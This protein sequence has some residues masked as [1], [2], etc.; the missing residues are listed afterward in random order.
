MA[1]KALPL[2]HSTTH[3]PAGSPGSSAKTHRKLAS[4]SPPN[5]FEIVGLP[6]KRKSWQTSDATLF[7]QT[8]ASTTQIPEWTTEAAPVDV[9][10][11]SSAVDADSSQIAATRSLMSKIAPNVGD[12]D[13]LHPISAFEDKYSPA[14]SARNS[15][16]TVTTPSLMGSV[17]SA[18]DPSESVL[19]ATPDSSQLYAPSSS[20]HTIAGTPTHG[21]SHHQS[22]HHQGYPQL[23]LQTA[24][25]PQSP[26]G[27]FGAHYHNNS[28]P[29]SGEYRYS[30][31]QMSY[32][33]P[34][35][36]MHPPTLFSPVLA[37]PPPP[38]AAHDY[39]RRAQPPS[40]PQAFFSE[41]ITSPTIASMPTP[42][43][44]FYYATPSQPV[45]WNA[46]LPPMPPHLQSPVVDLGGQRRFNSNHG[47]SHVMLASQQYHLVNGMVRPQSFPPSKSSG[48]FVGHQSNIPNPAVKSVALPPRGR[49]NSN[50]RPSPTPNLPQQTNHAVNRHVRREQRESVPVHRSTVLEDFRNNRNKRWDLQDIAGHV[51][52][53]SKDQHGSRFIQHKLTTATEANRNMV[54]RE[55]IPNHVISS[56]QNVFGNYVLQRLCE[57]GTPEERASIARTLQGHIVMLSLDIYGCRVLQKMIDY[58]GAAE[59]AHWVAE[60]HGH[61]LQCVKDA[62]GN[63]VIQKF[64]ESPLSDH[65]LFVNT[66]KTHVFEMATHPY[67]CR[68]LQR[69]FEHV[70][71]ELT[72]PLLNEMH[73]RTLELMQD[74]YGNYVMQFILEKGSSHDRT[75]VIQ[76]LTGHMLPMSKH[77][78]ASNVCE[79]AILNGTVEQRR[80]LIEEI[81]VQRPDG[82]N[83]I[84]TMIKDQFAN[85][86]LQR[87]LEVAE[88]K[89]LD[90][91]LTALRPQLHN[92]RRYASSGPF[93][94]HII[95]VEKILQVRNI[96]INAREYHSRTAHNANK[97]ESGDSSTP[98]R[99]IKP[100]GI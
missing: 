42:G 31:E 37:H 73:L 94:K 76:A 55:I 57:L 4:S 53:F 56:A 16:H 38:S 85:Y 24:H 17:D 36:S 61:I 58:L 10:S 47:S 51:V 59:Q 83:P 80:P 12:E 32:T 68:V 3:S 77:K 6:N 41:F 22:H 23:T 86:V 21:V 62:N 48:P 14:S 50:N 84:I 28:Y 65:S 25:L 66:F 52:E 74:Q 2:S 29:A 9:W 30:Y 75:R 71:P 91:L 7:N 45:N 67:G 100:P 11:L 8:W 63:H 60:L 1:T 81:S 99:E 54:Y 92:M 82:M 95:A 39:F 49:H 27:A 44:G 93:A 43:T 70:E 33:S 88:G 89:P 40:G 20:F 90:A 35:Q 64:L 26:S 46:P 19:D 78:Y 98:T 96:D 13:H 79:K 69:C 15:V 72:R 18:Q 34:T 5:A 87:A 97:S